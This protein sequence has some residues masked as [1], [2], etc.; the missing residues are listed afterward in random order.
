[1]FAARSLARAAPRTVSRLSAAARPSTLLRTTQFAPLRSSA[2][3]FSTS[4]F[5]RASTGT[6]DPELSAKLNSEIQFETEMKENEP[7]PVSVKDFIENG[8]FEVVDTP[9]LQDVV[10]TRTYGNEKITV[11]FSIADIASAE[12]DD[13]FRDEAALEDEE[14]GRDQESDDLD[15]EDGT[16]EPGVTCRLNIV[17]EKPGKG[18]LN[19]EAVAQEASVIVENLYYYHDAAI[20]HSSS[21][22]AVHKSRDVYPGPPFGTLD[23]D[24]Q[25]LMEQYLDERGINSTLAL[26]V[27]EYMDFKEQREY[28]SWLN[29]VKGFVDA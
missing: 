4:L 15:G 8:P 9:G 17:V 6:V 1:M 13:I 21:A 10:L 22:E 20:A 18:A 11:T 19:I 7:Q 28:L 25:L 14:G 23:E 26:F 27:P 12:E 16:G 2:S 3:A 29:N 24:L 5:R